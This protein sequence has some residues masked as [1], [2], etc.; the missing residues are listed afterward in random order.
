[1]Y[2]RQ[3]TDH[4]PNMVQFWTVYVL[5]WYLCWAPY[6][7]FARSLP[8]PG[9][10]KREVK[11]FHSTKIALR[12]PDW[13]CGQNKT[14]M[15]CSLVNCPPVKNRWSGHLPIPNLFCRNV[16]MKHWGW[17]CGKHNKP[18]YFHTVSAWICIAML[19]EFLVSRGWCLALPLLAVEA[20][21]KG[22]WWTIKK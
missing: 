16:I 8:L 6:W 21:W 20:S 11:V 9:P 14:G 1:V 7:M 18:L 17:G 2:K 13:L 22:S 19:V 15:L 12:H 5:T 10:Y 3:M 4:L